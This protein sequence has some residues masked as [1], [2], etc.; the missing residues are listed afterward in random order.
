MFEY[1][2]AEQLAREAKTPDAHIIVI[3]SNLVGKRALID[4]I[5]RALK[6]PTKTIPGMAYM[7][8]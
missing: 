8:P 5:S 7:K 2:S 4:A 1:L 6:V 3:N